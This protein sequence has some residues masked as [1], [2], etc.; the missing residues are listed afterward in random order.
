MDI[1]T[2]DDGRNNRRS[3]GHSEQ[4]VG[5]SPAQALHLSSSYTR[6]VFVSGSRPRIFSG[7]DGPLPANYLTREERAK[8][9]REEQNLL[10][11]NDIITNPNH[12]LDAVM[13]GQE[14]DE[15]GRKYSG[16]SDR[17]SPTEN[18]GLLSRD[19]AQGHYDAIPQTPEISQDERRR[20]W[21]DAVQSHK[22]TTSWKYETKL[23]LLS[24]AP[25]IAT[26]SLQYSM[27]F[28]SIFTLGHLGRISLAS[29][30]LA[31]MTASITLV[32]F[33]QGVATSLDTLCAQSFGANQPHLLGLHLQRCLL[34]LTAC[35]IP[36]GALWFSSEHI[37][38]ALK[39]PEEVAYYSSLYLKV[40]FAGTPG[41]VGFEAL[42]RFTTAQGNY[43]VST[44]CLFLAAPVNA[45]LNYV[46]VYHPK[47][48]FG[49]AGAPAAM[50]IS[51][52]LMFIQMIFYVKYGKSRH[53]WHGFSR[54]AFRS[55]SPML[56]LAVPGVVMTCSEW[57]A[58]EIMAFASSFLGVVALGAQAVLSTTGS[59]TYQVPFAV[60]VG[61]GTRVGNL[62]GAGLAKP[63]QTATTVGVV[64]SII[65]GSLVAISIVA[66]RFDWGRLFSDDL[67]VIALSA[68][69][70]PLCAL[71]N[72]ADSI[73]T[74]TA[75]ILRGQGQQHIGGI[76]NI[77]GYYV[78]AIP[79][80]LI[81]CFK[82]DWGLAGLWTGMCVAVY[83]IG[84]GQ[85]Y[86]VMRADWERLVEEVQLRL[87]AGGQSQAARHLD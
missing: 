59:L 47:I 32:A 49:F 39:Q 69:L 46:L 57:F 33:S 35:L 60:S 52:W 44:Y 82:L 30:S 74:I 50:S 58:Y 84:L 40:L 62:L 28:A 64:A 8:L 16:G 73:N 11:N 12:V 54:Q 1:P 81:L 43:N 20:K 66:L 87:L 4:Q 5:A 79:L 56:R 71:F 23:L 38:L 61:V 75:G 63:A 65:I 78:V 48:G 53:S 15:R 27:Q 19:P 22:L 72:L 13:E 45:I 31:S 17:A 77:I 2:K 67:E 42:K 34:L 3:S 86:Y 68:Q 29:S 18:T 7:Y 70:L 25:L 83:G 6:P 36:I 24:A 10:E 80:G 55:W 26:F 51:Y 41:Y 14:A 37:F 76:L 85:L 21:E 9:D